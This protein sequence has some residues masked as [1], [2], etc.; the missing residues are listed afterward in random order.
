[1]VKVIKHWNMLPRSVHLCRC[2][3]LHGPGQPQGLGINMAI[4]R[5]RQWLWKLVPTECRLAASAEGTADN[6]HCCP[7]PTTQG[8]R[9]AA[10]GSC[11]VTSSAGSVPVPL[12]LPVQLR[13]VTLPHSPQ[14]QCVQYALKARPLRRYIPKNPYQ[15]Q[16]WYVVTSS[17]FEYLMFFLIM[18]NTIC[19]GMQVRDRVQGLVGGVSMA[20]R[21][22]S[23]G[24]S[25]MAALLAWD[26]EPWVWEKMDLVQPTPL[27][28]QGRLGLLWANGVLLPSQHY[29]QSAEMNH[30]SDILNVAFTVLFTLEMILKLMAFK[31]KVRAGHSLSQGIAFGSGVILLILDDAV[32][33]AHFPGV[34]RCQWTAGL[35]QPCAWG[36]TTP[37]LLR[38]GVC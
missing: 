26:P 7:C 10:M 34:P 22:P 38:S 21:N 24:L 3:E 8:Y 13:V 29:N 4:C 18:L 9:L 28:S 11:A 23:W 12:A 15:Y 25:Y 19:L 30:V 35:C 14:R 2:S 32:W 5:G 31:A 16:I 17:Y 6:N 1:M 36:S 20:P 27:G 37:W 33:G